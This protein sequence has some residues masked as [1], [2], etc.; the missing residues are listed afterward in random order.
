MSSFGYAP[1]PSGPL[2]VCAAH[3]HTTAIR[4]GAR[5]AVVYTPHFTEEGTKARETNTSPHRAQT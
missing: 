1:G 4:L 5:G 2:H 3:T